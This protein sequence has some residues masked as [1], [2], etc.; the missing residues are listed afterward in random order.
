MSIRRDSS[1]PWADF[2]PDRLA[3][4]VPAVMSA[5]LFFSL[6]TLVMDALRSRGRH[7]HA[8][9]VHLLGLGVAEGVL[10][11]EGK[12]VSA[13]GLRSRLFYVVVAV[14]LAGIAAYVLPGAWFNYHRPQ[15]YVSNIAWLLTL[16]VLGSSLLAW[17]GVTA[18]AIAVTWPNPPLWTRPMITSTPLGMLAPRDSAGRVEPSRLWVETTLA[19]MA[20]LLGILTIAVAQDTFSVFDR[21][22]FETVAEWELN[23][24]VKW[25]DEIGRTEV[26]LGIGL[27]IGIST[28]RCR[29]FATSYVA[30]VLASL[31]AGNLLRNIVG[32]SRPPTTV[33]EDVTGSFPSGHVTQLALL[34]GLLPVAGYVLT[35]RRVPGRIF[36]AVVWFGVAAV[37]V[38]RVNIAAHWP[39]D[40]LGGI[41]LG[42]TAAAGARWVVAHRS[43]HDRCGN[44]VF[45]DHGADGHSHEEGR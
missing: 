37:A 32:R 18:A 3:V 20:T 13:P 10:G 26:V 7:F 36:A 15:G 45:H 1:D 4:F 40:A 9:K 14:A 25:L 19:G 30:S 43:W 39:T 24:S 28:L 42:T 35:R 38:R 17:V 29:V 2:A 27:L 44:C 21:D 6:L 12:L 8:R 16:S 11:E 5:G 34:A 23:W 31:G 22:V 41:L 33:I